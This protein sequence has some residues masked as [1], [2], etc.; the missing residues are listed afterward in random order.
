MVEIENVHK[1]FNNKKI[2][3]KLYNGGIR[4]KKW[5]EKYN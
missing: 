2:K 1:R 4:R 5:C 3:G